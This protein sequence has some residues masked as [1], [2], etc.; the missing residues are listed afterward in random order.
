MRI[1]IWIICLSLSMSLTVSAQADRWQQKIKYEM[2]IDFDVKSHTFEGQQKI[3]YWNNSPDT[4][5]KI[6]YH[7]YFNAF[8]PGSMMDVRSRTI[9][10]ADR[11]VADRISL[12]SDKEIGYQKVTSLT[13][14][15]APTSYITEG[16]ILEVQL[17][18]PILP[19]KTTELK[20]TFDAQC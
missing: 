8:Q 16:T 12:L 5:D 9:S 18:K 1:A 4:L 15:G 3:K 2:E 6:F 11:R 10:D 20:M 13:Q 7:L 14:D 19:G 17:A